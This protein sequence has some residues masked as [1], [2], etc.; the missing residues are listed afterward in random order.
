MS[1]GSTL[2]ASRGEICAWR[3]AMRLFSE[4]I[5]LWRLAAVCD[6]ATADSSALCFADSSASSSWI[7]RW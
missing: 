5:S 3:T 7:Y 1:P 2:G 4:S 6:P